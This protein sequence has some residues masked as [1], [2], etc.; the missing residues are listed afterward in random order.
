MKYYTIFLG[1]KLWQNIIDDMNTAEDWSYGGMLW[2]SKRK[3]EKCI[4]NLQKYD[5]ETDEK[6]FSV[7]ELKLK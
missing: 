6:K 1:K 4:D 7:K 3:A 2:K 5:F